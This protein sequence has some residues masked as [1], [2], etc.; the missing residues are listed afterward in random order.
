M[1]SELLLQDAKNLLSSQ[2]TNTGS[3]GDKANEI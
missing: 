1:S 3:H 2:R